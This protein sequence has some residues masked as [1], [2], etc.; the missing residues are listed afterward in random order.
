MYL[1]LNE[2]LGFT[3]RSIHAVLIDEGSHFEPV[4]EVDTVAPM[5]NDGDR[6][7]VERTG[8]S[9]HPTDYLAFEGPSIQIPFSGDGQRRLFEVAVKLNMFGENFKARFDPS[10]GGN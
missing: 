2:L 9:V 6:R 3:G 1:G 4:R 8:P 10:P 7:Y 5:A